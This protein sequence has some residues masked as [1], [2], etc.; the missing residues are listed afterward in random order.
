LDADGDRDGCAHAE[1]RQV[2]DVARVA[3]HHFRE[4]FAEGHH[5][6]GFGADGRAGCA[7]QNAK[8]TICSTSP[9]AMASMML[10]GNTC[11][12]MLP[13]WAAPARQGP[14]RNVCASFMPAPGR[15]R[16]TA[17]SPRNSAKRGDDFEVD[18]GLQADAAHAFQVAAPAMPKTSV[19]KISGAMMERMSRR[20]T[21]LTGAELPRQRGSERAQGHA[22]GHA[23]ED[24]GGQRRRFN[25]RPTS[26]SGAARRRTS[27]AA[28]GSGAARSSEL[29]HTTESS[30]LSGSPTWPSMVR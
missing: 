11:S 13:G 6:L 25:A 27:C 5:R 19:P 15:T 4:R 10:A 14:R 8:T 29:R 7:E 24:P 20:K 23:D 18:D 9:R 2:H 12:M 3:E 16:L 30:F 26:A 21:L 28:A 17:A 22:R 1:R